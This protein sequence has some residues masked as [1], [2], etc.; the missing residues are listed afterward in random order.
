MNNVAK[1]VERLEKQVQPE[2][3]WT[4]AP[5]ILVHPG[6]TVDQ[7]VAEYEAEHGPVDRNH[8][9]IVQLVESTEAKKHNRKGASNE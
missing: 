1:R 9:W 4:P 3:A 7:K 2:K 8:A 5:I 6:E